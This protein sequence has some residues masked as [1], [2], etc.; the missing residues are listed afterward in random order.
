MDTKHAA[1]VDDIEHIQTEVAQ[2]VGHRFGEFLGRESREP[3]TVC[4][5]P[6]SDFGH[7]YQII[8]VRMQGLANQ[9]IGDVR[10]VKVAG[11]DVVRATCDRFT[12]HRKRSIWVPRPTEYARACEL[13]GAVAKAPYETVR[14]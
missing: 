6:G 9:P 1:Q 12:Q 5:A 10:A 7:D 4:A 2:I 14:A 3:R 13:H 11:V 8:G